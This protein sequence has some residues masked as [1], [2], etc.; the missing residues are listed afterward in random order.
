MDIPGGWD[1][2]PP[3]PALSVHLPADVGYV[4]APANFPKLSPTASWQEEQRALIRC[5]LV[6][7]K[8]ATAQVATPSMVAAENAG[9]PD[10]GLPHQEVTSGLSG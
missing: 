3:R 10:G 5:R 9:V 1:V 7:W 8:A 2:P 6:R 4:Q